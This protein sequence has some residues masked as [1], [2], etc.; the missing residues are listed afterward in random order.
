M[1]YADD[2]NIYVKSRRAAKRAMKSC[3]CFPE[4]T[5]KLKVNQDKSQVGSQLRLKFL[6]FSLCKIKG[7]AGIRIH[8]KSQKRFKD[9]VRTITKRNRRRSMGD[10]LE[11]LGRN[12]VWW[13]GSFRLAAL[14]SRLDDLDGWIRARV[15]MYLRKQRKRVRTRFRNLRKLGEWREQAWMRANTRRGYWRTS[16]TQI[17]CQ[18]MTNADLEGIGLISMSEHCK[19]LRIQI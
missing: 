2:C 1:R 18:S 8:E 15:R 17:L 10:M 6:E 3:A 11:E 14:T 7:K 13:L 12:V 19:M 16:N 9:K 4:G 5:L